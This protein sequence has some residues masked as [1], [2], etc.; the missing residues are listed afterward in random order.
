MG[1]NRAYEETEEQRYLET[2]LK[3]GAWL[4][5]HQLSDGSWAASL[6]GVP[7]S[8]DSF[9]AW[10]LVKLCQ[11]SRDRTYQEAARKSADWCLSQ[12]M[13]NGY[14]DRC[15][16]TQDE[17]PW[18]HSIGYAMQGLLETGILLKEDKYVYAVLKSAE[19]LLRRYSIKGF[20]SLYEQQRGFLPA[21]FDH[22]WKSN[23]K[24]SCLTGN[25]QVSLFW[26]KLYLL[27]RDIRYLNGALKLNDDL[28]TLQILD[29]GNKGIRGG[30]KGSHPIYG[31]Y[32]TFRYPNWATKFFIDAL[33]AEEKSMDALRTSQ[34]ERLATT[35]DKDSISGMRG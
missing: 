8:Y 17:L 10:P 20:K 24:F 29:S 7:H 9:I 11:L 21:R 19:A 30:M 6:R 35:R 5:K 16:H 1:L 26:S 18:T 12:Q 32:A 34:H 2:A 14:F 13:E 27:T 4:V 31:L 28:K 23:D 3:A 33:I 15:S 25:A 22:K